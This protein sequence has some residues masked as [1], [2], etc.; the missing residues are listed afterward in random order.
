ME[1]WKD[2]FCHW[3]HRRFGENNFLL[4]YH[5]EIRLELIGSTPRHLVHFFLPVKSC[6]VQ[7]LPHGLL[8]QMLSTEQSSSSEHCCAL[9]GHSVS[10]GHLASVESANNRTKKI[11]EQLS[12]FQSTATIFFCCTYWRSNSKAVVLL[13]IT[14]L[15]HLEEC[16]KRCSNKL[17]RPQNTYTVS[18]K[19]YFWF[20]RRLTVNSKSMSKIHT[21]ASTG[22]FKL[23]IAMNYEVEIHCFT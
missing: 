1:E 21:G 6:L 8:Q 12:K 14:V 2:T 9:K 23:H 15:L 3:T 13:L 20:L 10:I 4:D 22:N 19:F 16:T 7:T 11:V 5:T 18:A 17:F